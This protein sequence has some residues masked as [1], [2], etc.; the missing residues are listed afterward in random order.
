MTPVTKPKLRDLFRSRDFLIKLRGDF[1]TVTAV[2]ILCG[3]M[4][5]YLLRTGGDLLENLVFSM[6]IG[7]M[8]FLLINGGAFM[9]WGERRVSRPAYYLLCLMAAPVALYVGV[10]LGSLIY[11]YPLRSIA[12]YRAQFGIGTLVF[13]IVASLVTTAFFWNKGKMAELTANAETEKAR[14]AAIEKQAMQAQLQLLQ[15]QIEPH[16]LFNTLANLQTLIGIDQARA[17]HML[18]QLIQYLR[19][20]L[21][22][23]RADQTSLQQEFTLMKAYLE[24]MSIRMGKR[25][26]Y[27]LDL[28]AELQTLRIPPMLLQPL[29][30]NAI[31][32]GVEPKMEGGSVVV[33][34][35]RANGSL[36]LEVADTGLGLPFDHTTPGT[37]VD[38]VGSHIGNANVSDRILA[39][40]GPEAAFTL[41]ANQ[42]A[43]VIARLNLPL[44]DH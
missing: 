6:C 23:S 39:I 9:I 29:V 10:N 18:D 31:K 14:T 34:A 1:I 30:E 15:A 42:P 35:R 2:N 26:S 12:S 17:Q 32:H 28:P 27:T 24:L 44:A 20:T 11:G 19:A 33:T 43:G 16:M 21:S 25:L 8:A 5:T 38:V 3:F 40:Y 4:L 7:N 13:T 36:L 22:S 41:E 37:D